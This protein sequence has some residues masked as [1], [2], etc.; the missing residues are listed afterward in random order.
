MGETDGLAGMVVFLA[1][2]GFQGYAAEVL[3]DGAVQVFPQVV[4]QA[5]RAVVAVG[6]T[7]SLRG[8]EFVFRSGNDLGNV[9]LVG[10]LGQNVTA[11]RPAYAVHQFGPAEFAEQLFQV[12]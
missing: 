9:D 7:A 5:W 2:H 11:A 4:G 1:E 3:V 12:G 8:I 10:T 6:L